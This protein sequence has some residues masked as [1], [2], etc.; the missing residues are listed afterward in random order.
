MKRKLTALFLVLS[1]MLSGCSTWI[2]GEYHSVKPHEGRSPQKA[3]GVITVDGYQGLR[4][5][6]ENMVNSGKETQTLYVQGMSHTVVPANIHMAIQYVKEKTPIGAYAVEEITYEAGTSGEVSAVAIKVQY[7]HDL[8]E[9]RRI[10]YVNGEAAAA[11]LVI[12]A[13]KQCETGI[14]L[15]VSEYIGTD[16]VQLVEDYAR[17]NPDV[18]MEL[19]QVTANIYPEVGSE[20]LVELEFKYQ[21]SRESLKSMQSAVQQVFSAAAPYV[22]GAADDAVKFAQMYSFLMERYHYKVE[23]SITPAYSLLLHGVGDS[24]TFATV[25]AAMCRKAKLECYVV[26]GTRNGEPWFWNII[27]ANGQCMH[28]DL[29][30][31]H[32]SGGYR[33]LT[34]AQMEGYVWD[35]S[36]YPACEFIPGETTEATEATETETVP[37][38]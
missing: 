4:L 6:L 19:P 10:K 18:V 21:T 29:L 12:N 5:A 20:R 37:E 7:T 8:A 35:Y 16:Y 9:L 3:D 24:R 26:S 22:S 28:L 17:E 23:T 38:E 11:T 30:Q 27:S 36:A 13:L 32:Q 34:D 15:H 33:I 2:D 14:V 1:L 31:S 25:Y